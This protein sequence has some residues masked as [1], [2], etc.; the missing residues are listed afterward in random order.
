MQSP[1]SVLIKK[2]KHETRKRYNFTLKPSN[3]GKLNR[4]YKENGYASASE[5][6]DEHIESL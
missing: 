4:L 2:H 3:R 5:L 1:A 6:L